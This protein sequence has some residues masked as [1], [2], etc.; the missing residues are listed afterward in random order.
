MENKRVAYDALAAQV[1]VV[2]IWRRLM[3]CEV[4]SLRAQAD[5]AVATAAASERECEE[6]RQ[7]YAQLWSRHSRYLPHSKTLHSIIKL[8]FSLE[9]QCKRWALAGAEAAAAAQAHAAM[10]DR[11]SELEQQRAALSESL[12]HERA[13]A[14][15]SAAAAAAAAAVL[16]AEIED[17]R[18]QVRAA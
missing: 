5:A 2:F 11:C 9:A 3:L 4:D 18:A 14:S 8:R 17:L 15:A 10:S 6:L 12:A 16:Q 7:Q 13:A 1:S